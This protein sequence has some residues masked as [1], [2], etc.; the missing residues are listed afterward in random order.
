MRIGTFVIEGSTQLGIISDETLN[1][2]GVEIHDIYFYESSTGLSNNEY[3]IPGAHKLYQNYPNPF[4]PNTNIG[5]YL[6]YS[7]KVILEIY[8]IRGR[9]LHTIINDELIMVGH[10][11]YSIRSQNLDLSSGIYIYNFETSK[12][13]DSRKMLILK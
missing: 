2:R 9:L 6:P 8:D 10:H 7:E 1:Y 3:I 13:K 12:F 11:E 5:F 4:N